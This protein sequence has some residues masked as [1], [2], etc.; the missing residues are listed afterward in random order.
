MQGTIPKLQI[1]IIFI[2]ISSLVSTVNSQEYIQR[3]YPKQITL[4]PDTIT[5]RM[6]IIPLPGNDK[7][8]MPIMVPDSSVIFHLKIQGYPEPISKMHQIPKHH[9]KHPE[10]P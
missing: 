8:N 4:L 7:Y 3:K 6:P 2:I 9:K 5:E 10:N 1:L